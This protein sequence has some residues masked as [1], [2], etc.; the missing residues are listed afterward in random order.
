MQ[1]AAKKDANHKEIVDEFE[2]LGFVVLDLSQ[3]KNCCDIVV[4]KNNYT[5]LIE[6]KDG[7][8]IPSRRKLTPGEELFALKWIQ[9]GRWFKVEN[10]Q[11]VHE[12]NHEANTHA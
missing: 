6:I 2:S 1:R 12:I 10:I 3:L 9:G 4:A 7:S 11:D 8:Q 5:V